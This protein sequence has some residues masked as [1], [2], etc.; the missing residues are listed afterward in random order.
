MISLNL[1]FWKIKKDNRDKFSARKWTIDQ[2]KNKS[3][4]MIFKIPTRQNYA[5]QKESEIVVAQKWKEGGR[6]FAYEQWSIYIDCQQN[7]VSVKL[8]TMA[9]ETQ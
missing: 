6:K 7:M 9:E 2:V 8:V 3:K 5:K 1:E 4:A